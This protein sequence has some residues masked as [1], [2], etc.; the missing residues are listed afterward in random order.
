MTTGTSKVL[1]SEPF[2]GSNDIESYITHFELLALLQ[3]WRRTGMRDGNEV[4]INERMHYFALQLHKS[5][6]DFY[7]TLPDAQKVAMMKL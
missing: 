1:L 5:A 2:T 7:R 6:I 3:K 4:E